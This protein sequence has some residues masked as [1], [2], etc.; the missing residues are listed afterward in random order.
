MK[1]SFAVALLLGESY[2][3][4]IS[5]WNPDLSRTSLVQEKWTEEEHPYSRM[6]SEDDENTAHPNWPSGPYG[7]AS[8]LIELDKKNGKDQ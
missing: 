5:K 1:I 6:V 2:A 3:I 4:K 7:D 8:E